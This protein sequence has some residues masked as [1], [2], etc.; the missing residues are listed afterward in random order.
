M[1]AEFRITLAA[2]RSSLPTAPASGNVW[3]VGV[4]AFVIWATVAA[5][6]FPVWSPRDGGRARAATLGLLLLGLS[7][8]T[9]LTILDANRSGPGESSSTAESQPQVTSASPAGD[10]SESPQDLPMAGSSSQAGGVFT[11]Y[12]VVVEEGSHQIFR[13]D[14]AGAVTSERTA[15]FSRS[16]MAAVERV[17]APGDVVHWRTIAGYHAGWS[18]LPNRSGPFSARAVFTDGD[19]VLRDA[20]LGQTGE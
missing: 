1:V 5:L 12:E 3:A 18:Y 9:A 11:R 2:G 8:A 16:S 14:A 19:G 20:E 7:A 6:L 15:T 13:V 4:L 10:G 17:V